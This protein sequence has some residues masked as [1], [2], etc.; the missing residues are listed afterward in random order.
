MDVFDLMA[1]VMAVGAFGITTVGAVVANLC[2]IPV[3]KAL[4]GGSARITFRSFAKITLTEILI[5]TASLAV[6]FFSVAASIAGPDIQ[7]LILLGTLALAT[8]LHCAASII[9]HMRFLEGAADRP[10]CSGDTSR[11]VIRAA[12]MALLT[13]LFVSLLTVRALL[14]LSG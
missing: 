1:V 5:M 3:V 9:P 10:N 14:S 11:D 2:K 12:L 8:V 6:G 4:C 13:P 7:G